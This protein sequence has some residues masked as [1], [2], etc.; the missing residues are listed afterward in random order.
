VGEVIEDTNCLE[1][2]E[3]FELRW[4]WEKTNVRDCGTSDFGGDR[5]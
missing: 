2:M 3:A 5:D 4:F 1:T